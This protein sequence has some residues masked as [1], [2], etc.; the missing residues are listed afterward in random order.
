M[1]RSYGGTGY[2]IMRVLAST[3]KSFE[4]VRLTIL[5]S[6]SHREHTMSKQSVN[7][8]SRKLGKLPVRHDPR[9]FLMAD[10][11][12]PANL[13][14]PPVQVDWAPAVKKPW[15][16]MMN[17][18]LG[19]CTCAAAGHMIELWTA[20]VNSAKTVVPAD[21]QILKA[22]EVVSGYNPVTKK[23]DNGAVELDV[24]KY[25][26]KSGVGGHKIT[27]FVALEP[28]N[29]DH[30]KIAV[31]MFG[32]CYIGLSL[33]LSAQTQT[34]WSVPTNGTHGPGAPG[35]WGGHAVPVVAY[36]AHYLTVVTWGSL[37]KMT[38]TFWQAYC[39]EAYAVLSKDFVNP[40]GQTPN[41]FDWATLAGDLKKVA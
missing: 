17:D 39:E 18:K 1:L 24:L 16:M 12:V 8:A 5:S 3:K 19:D 26:R 28:S 2:T 7:N 40:K 29:T 32:G 4:A 21:T 36:D 6:L 14:A 15:G 10:Y 25:W 22:Y 13:P 38:W 11:L 20:N 33:P 30:V 31:D 37:K 23:N 27:A 9:T 41:G 35:S 34:I